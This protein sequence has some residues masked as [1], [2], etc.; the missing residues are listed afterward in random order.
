MVQERKFLDALQGATAYELINEKLNL[1]NLDGQ[2]LAV[3][4]APGQGLRGTS[5]LV[6]DYDSGTGLTSILP[7][8]T[9]TA[10][11]G[12]DGR[13]NGSAVCNR[14]FGAYTTSTSSQS[15][16]IVQV[17]LTRML[18]QP[19]DVMAQEDK[20]ITALKAAKKYQIQ[21]RHLMLSKNDGVVIMRLKRN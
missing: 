11:F 4:S 5:W 15:I 8:S 12:T 9:V 3:F 1:K 16:N 7:D 14:Y 2:V 17:G 18:C 13:V 20:F 21:G 6:T 19:A 10:T